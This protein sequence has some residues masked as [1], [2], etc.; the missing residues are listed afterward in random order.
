MSTVR[1]R[2]VLGPELAG[3][4]MTPEEFDAVEEWDDLYLYELINGVLVVSPSPDIGERAPNDLIGQLLRNYRDQH[5]KGAALDYTVTEHTIRTRKNRRRADRVLWCGLGRLPDPLHD[6]PTIAI[7]YVSRGRRSRTRDY[8]AKRAEYEK[9]GIDEYWVIDR[10]DRTLTVFRREGKRYVER[11][12]R[13]G[14]VYKSPR[15]PGFELP[16]ERVFAE[17]DLF[18]S[19]DA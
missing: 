18:R 8:E 2:L 6:P 7:E 13:E 15:L 10:F 19:E 16:L 5:P 14:Q 1:E 12:Y 3:T 11:V 17:A 9:I 4:L